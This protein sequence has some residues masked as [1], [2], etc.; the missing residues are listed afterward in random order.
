MYDDGIWT[1]TI[2]SRK[3]KERKKEWKKRPYYDLSAQWAQPFSSHFLF[4]RTAED[5]MFAKPFWFS[6]ICCCGSGSMSWLTCVCVFASWSFTW[7]SYLSPSEITSSCHFIMCLCSHRILLGCVRSSDRVLRLPMHGMSHRCCGG[8]L[9]SRSF[10]YIPGT[11][12]VCERMEKWT[13]CTDDDVDGD[14]AYSAAF[15]AK[16]HQERQN[17]RQA[18]SEAKQN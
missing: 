6:R 15:D 3:M 11:P 5:F 17:E 2:F 7:F 1:N 14:S 9:A 4:K 10:A 12:G 8:H 18:K 13:D 16:K